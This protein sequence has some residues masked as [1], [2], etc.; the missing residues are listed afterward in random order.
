MALPHL[1]HPPFLPLCIDARGSNRARVERLREKKIAHGK[2]LWTAQWDAKVLEGAWREKL[3]EY[4]GDGPMANGIGF[5]CWTNPEGLILEEDHYAWDEFLTEYGDLCMMVSTRALQEARFVMGHG[6]RW[7]EATYS[8]SEDAEGPWDYNVKWLLDM[9][10]EGLDLDPSERAQLREDERWDEPSK[11]VATL[12]ERYKTGEWDGADEEEW[13]GVSE[14]SRDDY[15]TLIAVA[16]EEA[17]WHVLRDVDSNSA[18]ELLEFTAHLPRWGYWSP[19]RLE[20]MLACIL[21][22]QKDGRIV[23]ALPLDAK[24][25]GALAKRMSRAYFE[26]NHR[27]IEWRPS[28]FE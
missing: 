6:A 20:A 24:P 7:E 27:L 10:V 23:Y 2:A 3:K 11:Y 25:G 15:E 5:R 12:L 28:L 22:I 16:F 9:W 18:P 13:K 1:P 17:P 26:R 4:F 19:L 8:V 21:A 14:Q